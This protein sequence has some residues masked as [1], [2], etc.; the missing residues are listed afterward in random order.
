MG[1]GTLETWLGRVSKSSATNKEETWPPSSL[2]NQTR[3]LTWIYLSM[4]RQGAAKELVRQYY[5]M[6][7]SWERWI[8][9]HRGVQFLLHSSYPMFP[10]APTAPSQP[11]EIQESS[12]GQAPSVWTEWLRP[13]PLP[14]LPAFLNLCIPCLPSNLFIFTLKINFHLLLICVL[15][16]LQFKPKAKQ[17]HK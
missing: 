15:N 3:S 9:M 8:Q 2:L 16:H 14:T 17:T 5:K 4:R 10:D 6:L 1:L 11:A 7:I 12:S 13:P